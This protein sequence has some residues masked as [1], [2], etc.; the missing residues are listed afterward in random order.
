MFKHPV[1]SLT[2]LGAACAAVAAI[3]AVQPGGKGWLR[4][5]RGRFLPAETIT[6]ALPPPHPCGKAKV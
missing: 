4:A 5:R 2:K 1:F 3:A 6:A